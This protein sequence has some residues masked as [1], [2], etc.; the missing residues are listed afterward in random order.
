MIFGTK[1]LIEQYEAR[2]ADLKKQ[3][4]DLRSLNLPK[5]NSYLIPA[6]DLEADAVMSG[7]E[8]VIHLSE[9][10]LKELEEAVSER[11]RLLSGTY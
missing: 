8:E 5:V 6:N 3:I 4:E 7:K 1:K 9:Q 10:E 11:D 2:I